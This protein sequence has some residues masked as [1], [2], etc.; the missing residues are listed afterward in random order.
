VKDPCRPANSQTDGV[1]NYCKKLKG[2]KAV[3]LIR[4]QLDKD[5]KYSFLGHW[6][7]SG[8]IIIFGTIHSMNPKP[9]Q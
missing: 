9:S 8:I 3:M 7:N 5:Q 4:A 2:T 1:Y 6:N